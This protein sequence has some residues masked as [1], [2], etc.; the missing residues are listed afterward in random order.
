M[1]DDLLTAEMTA[2][3]AE[4]P[5]PLAEAADMVLGNLPEPPGPERVEGVLDLVLIVASVI[6]L[7][8]GMCPDMTPEDAKAKADRFRIVERAVVLR[9]IR[10]AVNRHTAAER[11]RFGKLKGKLELAEAIRDAAKT[12]PRDQVYGV[13]ES[14]R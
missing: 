6:N 10:L 8:V 13:L 5:G 1:P 3:R 2:A 14:A 11:G 7:L 12:M 9:A 4:L